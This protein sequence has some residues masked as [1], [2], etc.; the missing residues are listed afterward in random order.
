MIY[1]TPKDIM[2]RQR[3]KQKFLSMSLPKKKRAELVIA[4]ALQNICNDA[5]ERLAKN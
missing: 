3:I 5:I 2:K 1:L 4:S